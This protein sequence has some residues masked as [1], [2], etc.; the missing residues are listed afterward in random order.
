MT[1]AAFRKPALAV[2]GTSEGSHGGHP[3]FRAG[4]KVFATL[5]YPDDRHAMVK[6][7]PD[8]QRM[9]VN[10]EPMMFVPVKG[11][12]GR[13]GATNDR[14]AAADV[15]TARSALTMAIGNVTQKKWK[16]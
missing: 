8:H 9:L 1:P 16:T 11:G 15:K 6:L 7:T 5:G 2:G 13:R 3:D 14:L 10:A 12:W 4:G